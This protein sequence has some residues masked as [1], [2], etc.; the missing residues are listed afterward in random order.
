M[1]SPIGFKMPEDRVSTPLLEHAFTTPL[2]K[3]RLRPAKA[4]RPPLGRPRLVDQLNEL[5][6]HRV[7]LLCAPAGFGKTTLMHQWH[8]HLHGQGMLVSWLSLN[9]D[10]NALPQFMLSLLTALEP[11][12]TQWRVPLQEV[13]A[14]DTSPQLQTTTAYLLNQLA[15][16]EQPAFLLLDD[17]Q[18]LH[19]PQVLSRLQYLLDL[20]P[21]NLH[22]GIATRSTSGLSLTPLCYRGQLLE[23]EAKELAFT[24]DEIRAYFAHTAS[25]HLS[26]AALR[27]IAEI[28]EGWPTGLQMLAL[29]S[30]F[31][32]APNDVLDRLSEG[33]RLVS[34]YFDEMVLS[35]LPTDIHDFLLQISIVD[36]L[37]PELCN[38]ITERQ[39]A[40]EV[41][42]WLLQKNL[43]ITVLDDQRSCYRLHHLFSET[44]NARLLRSRQ[45][46][47]PQL[48]ARASHHLARTNQWRDAIRHAL[49]AAPGNMAGQDL[50]DLETGARALA[51]HG[52][53]DTLLRWLQQLPQEARANS[54]R[55]QLTLAWALAHH[56]R[57]EECQELLQAASALTE[58]SGQDGKPVRLEIQAVTAVC[59]VLADDPVRAEELLVPLVPELGQLP[60]WIAGLV[61][62]GLSSS[63][64]A[65]G[66]H[67]DVLDLQRQQPVSDNADNLLVTLYRA[68]ILGQVYLRQADL[69]TAGRFFQ[70]ALQRAENLAGPQSNGSIAL[71]AHL[72]ELF[73]ERR[74]W[75]D[76]TRQIEPLLPLIERSATLDGLLKVY[77][78]LIRTYQQQMPGRAEQLIEQGLQLAQQ[79]N[80]PRFS[81]GMLSEAIHLKRDQ[82][83][84]NEA[85]TLL[86]Q[87]EELHDRDN[88]L[89]EAGRREVAELVILHRARLAMNQEDYLVASQSLGALAR[90]LLQRGRVLAWLRLETLRLCCEWRLGRHASAITGLLPLLQRGAQQQLRQSFVESS[91]ILV[92]LLQAASASPGC[93]DALQVY[94][95]EL[96]SYFPRQDIADSPLPHE[97]LLSEREQEVLAMVATGSANKVIA[98]SLTISAETVKWH[99]KNI[100]LKL[101]VGNRMQ[102]LIRARELGLV[103]DQLS[104]QSVIPPSTKNSA[105]VAKV[106]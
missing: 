65:Q 102:A 47:V 63:Y 53:L 55:L 104:P 48:H 44:L 13:L 84:E 18:T 31:Q 72:T 100:F 88:Q 68:G 33:V 11:L 76:L 103:P 7:A 69:H 95:D 59:A 73:H 8:D 75:P 45:H 70:D 80:W 54:L 52:D 3:T 92:E 86:A 29:N 42:H 26:A 58:Q 4:L 85:L 23:L 97:P 20:A 81:A 93:T 6:R 27:Q 99:L 36:E 14:R 2:V 19:D 30:R 12:H 61:C 15:D 74:Q 57:F 105:P 43:F 101:Q 39:D 37:T 94:I 24:A 87:L 66:R 34:R 83:L 62:N 67:A 10:D 28:S 78:S 91:P 32:S 22:L 41:L 60:P 77:R 5:T 82:G 89:A 9:G 38:A 64:L 25:L 21:D 56:F 49:H 71:R 50:G 17:V 96:L 79:R 35:A 1:N 46:D 98:R 51:E 106:D 90:Q 16:L 40:D